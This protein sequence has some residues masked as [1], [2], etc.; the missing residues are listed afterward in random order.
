MAALKW[1]AIKTLYR[2]HAMGRPRRV[3]ARYD[4]GV[5]LFEERVVTIRARAWDEAIR[6]GEREARKYA[7]YS[8][9][10]PYGQLV[11]MTYLEAFDCFEIWGRLG[12]NQEVFSSTA[13]VPRNR[14]RS[15]LIR[16]RLGND[17]TIET[18]RALFKFQDESL[19]SAV[20]AYERGR[21]A[22]TRRANRRIAAKRA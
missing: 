1:F 11:R 7:G 20:R 15:A 18:R 14:P 21:N 6:K 8:H 17:E 16:A 13:L 9:R 3:D 4:P 12:D 2:S 10:N 22:K 5:D 19:R